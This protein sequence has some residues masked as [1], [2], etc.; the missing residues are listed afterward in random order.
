[1]GGVA[2]ERRLVEVEGLAQVH[3]CPGSLMGYTIAAGL[4]HTKAAIP[5]RIA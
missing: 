2:G 4:L 5:A 1:M 3:G